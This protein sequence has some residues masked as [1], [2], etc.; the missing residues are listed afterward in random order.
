[1]DSL[2]SHLVP[3]LVK[4]PIISTVSSTTLLG[5]SQHSRHHLHF[6]SSRLVNNIFRVCAKLAIFVIFLPK[7]AHVCKKTTNIS[8]ENK[9]KLQ[10]N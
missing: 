7:V 1:M 9:V 8:F 4:Y 3:D 2:P 10:K 5:P 6:L